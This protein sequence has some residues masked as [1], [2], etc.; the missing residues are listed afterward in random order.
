MFNKWDKEVTQL[1][2]GL[3]KQCNKFQNGSIKFSLVTGIWIQCLQAYHW[4][5]QFHQNKVTH[6]GN[7]FQTCRRL[8][9][10]SLLTL[11]PDQVILNI[12]KCMMGLDDLKKDAPK[13]WNINLRERLASA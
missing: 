13:L 12:N 11:T 8:N 1:M 10:L 4:I 3:E 5:Q 9:I 7:L 2:L 6:R